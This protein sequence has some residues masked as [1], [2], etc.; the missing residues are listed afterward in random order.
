M[1]G[2]MTAYI[3]LIRGLGGRYTIPM[4]ELARILERQGLRDVKTYIASGNAVGR[5]G[6]LNVRKVGEQI[7]REIDRARGFAPPVILLSLDEL[8]RAI[9]RNPYPEADDAPKSLHLVFLD[10][11]P[12]KPDLA[13]VKR[14]C[15]PNERFTLD[16]KVFYFHAP[17]G[18]G[19]SKA[20]P[21]IEKALGVTCTARNWRTTKTLQALAEGLE[22]GG[23]P[24]S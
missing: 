2:A 3:A 13:T 9:A 21:R 1:L 4:T 24:A 8:T 7:T 6:K 18:V 16:G 22:A 17:D 19:K 20:F 12:K 5:A 10:E 15:K 14:L 23:A 11:A